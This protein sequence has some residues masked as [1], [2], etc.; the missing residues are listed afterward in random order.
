MII[1]SG[2][3]AKAFT[4]EDSKDVLI[5]ASGVANSKCT[6]KNEFI[7]E[8]NLLKKNLK[9]SNNKKFVYFSSCALSAKDYPLNEYYL[10]KKNMENII[11]AK[12]ENYYI[13]RLPQLIGNIFKE[14]NT[15]LNFLHHK[16]INEES[17]FIYKDGFRYVI[18]VNDVKLLVT[19]FIYKMPPRQVV[20][21]ANPYRYTIFEIVDAFE[22]ILNKQAHYKVID[23]HDSYYLNLKAMKEFIKNFSV[24][25]DFSEKYLEEKL[26]KKLI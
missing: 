6:D 14:H 13:I 20:D 21:F 23:K 3:I 4:H 26:G 2:Q 24:K 5:F 25:I 11:R 19:K 8:E 16:I 17:F 18:E 7:R 22:K 12:S 9:L 15:L 10:H 1:G